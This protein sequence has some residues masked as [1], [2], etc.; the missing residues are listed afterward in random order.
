MRYVNITVL[1]LLLLLNHAIVVKIYHP[2]TRLFPNVRYLI[3]ELRLFRCTA[4]YKYI[5]I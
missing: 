2:Y 5:S 1:L 4:P 3:G